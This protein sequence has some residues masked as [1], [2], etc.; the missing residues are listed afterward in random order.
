[1]KNNRLSWILPLIARKYPVPGEGPEI[2]SVSLI[3][4]SVRGRS[5]GRITELIEKE[6]RFYDIVE[7]RDD[8]IN[9]PGGTVSTIMKK[10]QAEEIP[11]IFT[12]RDNNADRAKL[13]YLEA[14]GFD[15]VALDLDVSL[16]GIRKDLKDQDVIF[17]YHGERRSPSEVMEEIRK[18]GSPLGKMAVP[19][20][21]RIS[22]L[23][24]LS[25]VADYKRRTG[26]PIAFMPMQEGFMGDRLLSAF[27]VSDLLYASLG[28]Q[29]ARGQPTV[30]EA[31]ALRK[32]ASECGKH[33]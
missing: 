19:Y 23:E 10:L 31:A 12:H 24:D 9:G 25:E 17:S 27:Y 2:S 20:R 14:T 6:R 18:M 4:A 11:F 21:N 3:V 7:I 13:S 33:G 30:R 28:K 26:Y 15:P 5:A 1:M 8:L 16:A 32:L 29:T 22:F